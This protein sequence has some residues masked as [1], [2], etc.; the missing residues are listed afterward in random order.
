MTNEQTSTNDG[1][2]K[3][4]GYSQQNPAKFDSNL[5]KQ[6]RNYD[7]EANFWND[8]QNENMVDFV[9]ENNNFDGNF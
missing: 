9:D 2:S 5:Q 3:L 6:Y 1:S 7:N 8:I 4:N